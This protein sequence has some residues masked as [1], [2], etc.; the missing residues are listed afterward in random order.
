MIKFINESWEHIADNWDHHG[1]YLILTVLAGCAHFLL[2]VTFVIALV[3]WD[4]TIDSE[5]FRLFLLTAVASIPYVA[6]WRHR[7]NEERT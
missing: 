4:F 2:F 5:Y 3:Q 1:G 6:Y 7:R